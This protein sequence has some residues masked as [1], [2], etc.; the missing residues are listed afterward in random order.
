MSNDDMVDYFDRL[1]KQSKALR[2]E[3]L[4]F[5][6]YMRGGLNYEDAMLLSNTDRELI[7]KIIKDNL[8]TSKK[9][10]MPFF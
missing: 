8:E 4:R 10:G 1:E 3:A 9:S 2:E 6:W 5:S 7:G